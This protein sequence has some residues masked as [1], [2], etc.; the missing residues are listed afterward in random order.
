M[1]ILVYSITSRGTFTGIAK[2]WVNQVRRH[3]DDAET[4]LVLIG[5]KT[6]LEDFREVGKEEGLELAKQI[7]ALFW[8]TS[9]KTGQSVQ[10]AFED[11]CKKLDE[12]DNMNLTPIA[13]VKRDRTLTVVS[14][15]GKLV[16]PQR[17]RSSKCC[18]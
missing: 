1:V 18:N 3:C 17:S 11:I 6:D 5:N 13:D 14:N 16:A 8:E 7:G 15:N 10:A 2:E 12:N 4:F 9:A